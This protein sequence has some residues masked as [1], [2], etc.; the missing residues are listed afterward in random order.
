MPSAAPSRVAAIPAVRDALLAI[1]ARF[2]RRSAAGPGAGAGAVLDGRDI[3][4]VICPDAPVKLFVTASL[5]ARAERRLEELRGRGEA[6]IY[7]RVLQ[8]MQ[9]RDARDRPGASPRC[10]RAPDAHV[11]DTTELDAD[12]VFAA[13]PSI[14]ST[15][16]GEASPHPAIGR[17]LMPADVQAARTR[18]EHQRGPIRRADDARCNHRKTAG[19]NRPAGQT[20]KGLIAWLIQCR[21]SAR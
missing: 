9:E 19:Y 13:W 11:L 17:R 12:Q 14:I 5:E 7:A 20:T 10:G 21:R 15:G 2:R 1:P 3:G 6:A 16:I 18:R 4:T 8:D